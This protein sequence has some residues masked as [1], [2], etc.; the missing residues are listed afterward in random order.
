S[1]DEVGASLFVL[2]SNPPEPLTDLCFLTLEQRVWMRAA[3]VP[4]ARSRL[5]QVYASHAN[6]LRNKERWSEAGRDAERTLKLAEPAD[7]A[8]AYVV[9]AALMRAAAAVHEGHRPVP[10]RRIQLLRPWLARTRLPDFLAWI[11]S[12]LA[13]LTAEEGSPEAG[14]PLSLQAC[15]VAEAC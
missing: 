7:E 13:K 12:D 2:I 11:L 1:D 6:Y 9:R 15:R 5:L 4:S 10:S 3:H 14:L 8:P